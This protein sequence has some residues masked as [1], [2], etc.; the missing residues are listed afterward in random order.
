MEINFVIR[1]NVC[2]CHVSSYRWV[3]GESQM[4][5]WTIVMVGSLPRPTEI[6]P[7]GLHE[8]LLC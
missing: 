7:K 1:C 8:L 5:Q 4:F 3:F 2:L 6:D